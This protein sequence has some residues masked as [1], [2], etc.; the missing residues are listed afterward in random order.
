MVRQMIYVKIT[1]N[2]EGGRRKVNGGGAMQNQGDPDDK[3]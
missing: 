1:E 3:G 2:C